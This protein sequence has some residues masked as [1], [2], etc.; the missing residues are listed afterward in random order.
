MSATAD[1]KQASASSLNLSFS[2]PSNG[3]F[4][5]IV[6]ASQLCLDQALIDELWSPMM[7]AWFPQGRNDPSLRLLRLEIQTAEYWDSPSSAM[8]RMAA[9]AASAVVGRPIGLG[10]NKTVQNR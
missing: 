4:V 8:V 5:S 10:E 2:D 9:I 3:T 1:A 7:K 6:G